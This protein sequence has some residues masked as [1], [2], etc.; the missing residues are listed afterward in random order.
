MKNYCVVCNYLDI[1]TKGY[2]ER[3]VVVEAESSEEAT[4]IVQSN[5]PNIAYIKSTY[6]QK[7]VQETFK[8][9]LEKETEELAG[10]L[11]KLNEFM[12]KKDFY[13][14]PREKKTLLYRQSRLMNEYLEV[15]GLR[16][17]L[18]KIELEVWNK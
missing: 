9:R 16:C 10:K 2:I 15:L 17:E 7:D 14:L 13:E 12:A 11:N 18:E 5:L 6:E 3:I 8:D 1:D 4:R